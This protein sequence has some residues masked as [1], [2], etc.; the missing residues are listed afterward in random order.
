LAAGLGLAGRQRVVE[1]IR[2]PGS[3]SRLEVLAT[4]RPPRSASWDRM[5]AGLD[6][7]S[8]I[9]GWR[10]HDLRRTA[11]TGWQRLGVEPHVIEQCLGHTLG[12]VAGVYRRHRYDDE[13]RAAFCAWASW[14][15]DLRKTE[16]AGEDTGG[17]T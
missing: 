12:G 14:L 8:G 11:A 6:K 15:E 9:T 1:L 5:K 10:L 4:F 3:P 16:P 7:A 17:L 2:Y 13:I